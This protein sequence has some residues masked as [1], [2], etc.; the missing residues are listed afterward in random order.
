V[1]CMEIN[2]PLTGNVVR[3]NIRS[4]LWKYQVGIGMECRSGSA[5][6]PGPLDM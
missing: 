4:L 6:N 3:K 1:I 2:I 5:S